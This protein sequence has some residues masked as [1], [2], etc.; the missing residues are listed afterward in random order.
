[1]RSTKIENSK[2]EDMI[3][4]IVQ[5][6]G[7]KANIVETENCFTRLRVVVKDPTAVTADAICKT[8]NYGVLQRGADVHIVYGTAADKIEKKLREYLKKE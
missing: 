1:M 4:I 6:L 3:P 7:G 8:G 2:I 5:G